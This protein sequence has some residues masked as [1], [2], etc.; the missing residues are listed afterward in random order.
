MKRITVSLDSID[1][2]VF[3][4]MNGVG[5]PAALVL[6]GIDAAVRVGFTPVKVNTVVKRGVNDA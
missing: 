6:E 4:R 5:F 1:E 2:T 3:Q